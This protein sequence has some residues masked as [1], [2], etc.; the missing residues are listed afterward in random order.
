MFSHQHYRKP[1]SKNQRLS[2]FSVKNQIFR[3]KESTLTLEIN[4]K[5]RQQ[6]KL[7]TIITN[8]GR[9]NSRETADQAF[10]HFNTRK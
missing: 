10:R 6:Q 3:K 2:N 5:N 7:E 9:C 4:Y 8:E 1:S